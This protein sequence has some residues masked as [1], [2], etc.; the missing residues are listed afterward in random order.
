[1]TGSVNGNLTVTATDNTI[2][3]ALGGAVA[4]GKGGSLGLSIGYISIN[5]TL[6]A[7]LS[8]ANLTVMGNVDVEAT[9]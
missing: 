3:V 8:N 6:E 4:V 9:R 1:M 5:H 2:Y 7:Y